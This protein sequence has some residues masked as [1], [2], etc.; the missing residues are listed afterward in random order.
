M[1]DLYQTLYDAFVPVER[2]PEECAAAEAADPYFDRLRSLVSHREA[3]EI[4]AA[5]VDLGAVNGTRDFI[6]GFRLGARLMLGVL[7]EIG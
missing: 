4:W 1:N 7:G 5:A 2:T 3:D 6:C